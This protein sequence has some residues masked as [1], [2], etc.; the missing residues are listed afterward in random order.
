MLCC[1][2]WGRVASGHMDGKQDTGRLDI[3]VDVYRINVVLQNSATT[4]IIL[5][6]YECRMDRAIDIAAN[7]STQPCQNYVH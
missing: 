5:D 4:K 7:T 2:T 6:N 1:V 3:Y